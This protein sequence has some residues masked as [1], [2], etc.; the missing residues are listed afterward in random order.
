MMEYFLRLCTMGDPPTLSIDSQRFIQLK[1]SKSILREALA[2]E[3]EYEI[4]ISNYIDLEKESVNVSISHMVRG[5]GSYVDSFDIRIAL[6]RRLMNLLTSVRLYAD[7]L[8]SHC[9]ACLPNEIGI[10]EEVKSFFSNEYDKNFNYRFMEA[11]R[12]HLQHYGTAVHQVMYGSR[13]T[14]IDIDGL[15][16]FSSNFSAEKEFL[17]AN[18][19]FKKQ[20]LNEMPEKVDLISASRGYIEALSSIHNKS[21]QT[22]SKKVDEAR[23][24]MQAAKD[25]YR[26][27]YKKEFVG[28]SAYEFD[29]AVK[30]DEIPI[31]LNWDDIRIELVKRNSYLVNLNKRYVTAQVKKK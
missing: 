21:R 20:I 5:Y 7:Q 25:D 12:N 22:I 1:T 11:L 9:S 27:V 16:E 10:K 15:L 19:H 26:A 13:W 18:S 23:A 6:N 2:L 3:E 4:V 17:V 14:S 28:L 8:A 24:I 31:L 29:G 30:T